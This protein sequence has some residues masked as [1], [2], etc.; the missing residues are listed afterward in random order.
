MEHLPTLP[1]LPYKTIVSH[2]MLRFVK[3]KRCEAKCIVASLFKSPSP[4]E[5]SLAIRK[6]HTT[7]QLTMY[8]ATYL[9]LPE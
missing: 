4:L 5:I 1:H 2:K 8:C 3:I 6:Y 9:E 7:D